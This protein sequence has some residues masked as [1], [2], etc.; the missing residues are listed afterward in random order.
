VIVDNPSTGT[1][2]PIELALVGLLT[3]RCMPVNR[4]DG[5]R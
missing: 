2:A 3:G 4:P 5:I 1:L